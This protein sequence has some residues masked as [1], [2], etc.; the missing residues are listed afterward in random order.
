MKKRTQFGIRG[1]TREIP[2]NLK[3]VG[4]RKKCWRR[5]LAGMVLSYLMISA[6][7]SIH[8]TYSGNMD[9]IRKRSP[10]LTIEAAVGVVTHTS[11]DGNKYGYDQYGYYIGYN[12]TKAKIGDRV[13][14]V[15]VWN[16]LNNCEDDI[17]GRFDFFY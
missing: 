6:L 13:L 9:A 2:S 8:V 15:V 12:N 14:T 11:E 1:T 3:N 7:L 5:A 4:K 16:P 10:F 17:I